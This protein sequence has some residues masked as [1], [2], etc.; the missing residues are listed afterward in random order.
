MPTLPYHFQ[1]KLVWCDGTY[2]TT[3]KTT[4]PMPLCLFWCTFFSKF[5][6]ASSLLSILSALCNPTLT[7]SPKKR[8]AGSGPRTQFDLIMTYQMTMY[9]VILVTILFKG[10]SWELHDKFKK[11]SPVSVF[12]LPPPQKKR[13][14]PAQRQRVGGYFFKLKIYNRICWLPTKIQNLLTF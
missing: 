8:N 11:T 7:V 14:T 1:V 4:G 13:E 6:S 10:K 12:P 5:D 3:I 2:K 9:T